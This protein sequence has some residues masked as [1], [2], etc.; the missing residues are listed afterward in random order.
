MTVSDL[1]RSRAADLMDRSGIDALVVAAPEAFRYVTGAPDGVA[2]LFRRAG[3]ALALV[4]KNPDQS[5]AAIVTD[6]AAPAVRDAVTDTRTHPMW[7]ETVDLSDRPGGMEAIES[8][9]KAEGRQPGFS[10]P[11]TF[12]PNAAFRHLRAALD[13][14]GLITG[15]IGLDL[16]F[17][18]VADYNALR[19]VL[20]ETRFEDGTPVLEGLRAVKSS[21]EIDR[22]TEAGLLAEAGVRAAVATLRPGMTRDEIAAAWHD[23]VDQEAA[24]RSAV[25]LTGRW[26]Y[27]AFGPDP[28]NGS[29]RLAEGDIV[30]FDVGTLVD[31]YSSDAARTFAFGQPTQ[32]ARAIH[33][34]LRAGFEA[35]LAVLGPG[36]PLS[37]VHAAATAAIQAAGLP[38]YSR[39]HFGHGLGAGIFGEMPPF[40]S[41]TTTDLAEPGMVLAFETP[42]YATGEGGFIIEDQVVITKAGARSLWALSR[43]LVVIEP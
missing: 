35:G 14:R 18:P 16:E 34:A 42:F 7:V 36:L 15:V 33:D 19:A 24:R 37:E 29:G 26:E 32:R 38:G 39:G 22:L 1:D 25:R 9:W 30:K 2:G 23:G 12:D 6:L 20:P 27:I 43:D 31:G 11:A 17:W 5:I 21:R 40:I 10:R 8:A 3:S 41:A 13:D 4:P 28:W